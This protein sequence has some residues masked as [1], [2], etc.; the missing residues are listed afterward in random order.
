[1]GTVSN[2]R[3]MPMALQP[4]ANVGVGQSPSNVYGLN[5][6]D[7]LRQ[8]ST[9]SGWKEKLQGGQVEKASAL[10]NEELA[11]LF[12]N[13][14]AEKQRAFSSAEAKKNRE[15]QERMSST[16]YQRQ[17]ADMRK[18]GLNPALAYTKLSGES[19]PSGATASS[20]SASTKGASPMSSGSGL[21]G[22]LVGTLGNVFTKVFTSYSVNRT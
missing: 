10:A 16:A 3:E 1:M 17:I 13:Y 21:L 9:Q 14:Q 4:F 20:G 22:S 6:V 18:A 2:Y 7:D 12:N 19:T 11:R 15:F 8:R 5:N